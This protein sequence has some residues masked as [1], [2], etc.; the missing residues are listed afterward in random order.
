[1]AA[2]AGAAGGGRGGT[3]LVQRGPDLGFRS[4]L[5]FHTTFA[6]SFV[7][8]GGSFPIAIG[9]GAASFQVTKNVVDDSAGW[10]DGIGGTHCIA[11][12]AP[13]RRFV[14]L[15]VRCSDKPL[16]QIVFAKQVLAR[17]DHGVLQD[18]GTDGALQVARDR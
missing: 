1:M 3:V 14:S 10:L 17:G 5:F 4:V 13:L 16:K 9:M 12:R 6:V 18:V 2:A 7:I 8:V 11:L 15:V